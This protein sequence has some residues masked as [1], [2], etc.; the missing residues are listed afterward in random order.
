M[1]EPAASSTLRCRAANSA[2][3]VGAAEGCDKVG[4]TFSDL[5]KATG[6]VGRDPGA[7]AAFG[8]SY[9]SAFS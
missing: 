8:S 7:I 5:K 2:S 4:T 3:N 9:E 1:R 6:S